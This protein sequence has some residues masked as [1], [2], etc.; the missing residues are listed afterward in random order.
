MNAWMNDLET[1]NKLNIEDREWPND[2]RG[3]PPSTMIAPTE[4][5]KLDEWYTPTEAESLTTI[6]REMFKL[7]QAML[8]NPNAKSLPELQSLGAATEK[9]FFGD[10]FSLTYYHWV[11]SLTVSE[12]KGSG[13]YDGFMN[14]NVCLN[15]DIFR[16]RGHHAADG[17]TR[18]VER[19]LAVIL[20]EQIHRF[21]IL[22]LC[23]G[24]CN[25]TVAQT[26]LCKF[27]CEKMEGM[28]NHI[29]YRGTTVSCTYAWGHGPAFAIL[30]RHLTETMGKY[31][32]AWYPTTGQLRILSVYGRN[33]T[34]SY[35]GVET[36]CW[37]HCFPEYEDQVLVLTE[38]FS[39]GLAEVDKA[40][41][42]KKAAAREK[43]EKKIAVPTWWDLTKREPSRW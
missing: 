11:E 30:A 38:W 22:Y 12:D 34:C 24:R 8:K 21:L 26:L 29:T 15:P 4:G 6:R 20:H 31:L 9:L 18:R 25:G 2:A 14:G 27:L 1:T 36:K 42:A 5:F 33:C 40:I 17:P 28:F 41:K 7:H 43:Y 16:G 13:R 37:A 35:Y 3:L 32:R 23:K 39:D 10:T 19:I